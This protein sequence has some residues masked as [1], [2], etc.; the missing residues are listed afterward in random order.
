M[1]KCNESM[2]L[3]LPMRVR[4]LMRAAEKVMKMRRE[5]FLVWSMRHARSNGDSVPV[6]WRK[7][8]MVPATSLSRHRDLQDPPMGMGS[9]S[10]GVVAAQSM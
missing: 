10:T 5:P 7:T 6:R 9:T 1:E 8:K 2:P 4:E 3:T